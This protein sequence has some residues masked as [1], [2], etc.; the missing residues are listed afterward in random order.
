MLYILLPA[1]NEERALPVLLPRIQQVMQQHQLTA[2]IVVVDDGSVDCTAEIARTCGA[3]EVLRHPQNMGLAAAWR[4]GL[5]HIVHTA[6]PDDVIVTMDA[7]NT[8]NPGLIPRML[9]RIDEGFDVVIASR[10]RPGARVVGVPYI[11]RLLSDLG[12]WVYRLLT[13]IPGVRDYTC[14]YRAYRAAVIQAAI[15]RWG[16]GFISETGFAA[17]VDILLKLRCLDNVLMTEL[18]FILRYDRKPGASKMRVGANILASLRLALRRAA[19]R[20]D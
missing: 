10:Y 8:H 15:E 4:T 1:Y 3:D 9:Q 14:G 17:T 20:L 11:R 19:G 12:G 7:D 18:P 6:Q 16:D 13:P 5:S 2:Q